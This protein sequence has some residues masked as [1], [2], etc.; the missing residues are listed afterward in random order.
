MLDEKEKKDFKLNLKEDFKK[1]KFFEEGVIYTNE[2]KIKD[3]SSIDSLDK[4]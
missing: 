3:N 4:I 2:R 1:T